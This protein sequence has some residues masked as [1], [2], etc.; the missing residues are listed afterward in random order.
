MV[1][2]R[3]SF[4]IGLLLF[5]STGWSRVWTTSSGSK[6]EGEL[7]EVL[8]DRIGLLIKGREYHFSLSRFIQ[9]DQDYVLRWKMTPRCPSCSKTLG[10]RTIDAGGVKYHTSCF[11]CMVC[12]SG[13]RGGG[14]VSPGCME[15]NG[16]C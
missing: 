3:T 4:W 11:R 1:F 2:L 7:F 5:C 10:T 15:W 8:G 16:S 9:A 12:R 13:F 6:S 14:P